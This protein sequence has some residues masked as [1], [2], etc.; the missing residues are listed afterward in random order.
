MACWPSSRESRSGGL[1]SARLKLNTTCA[2]LSLST[3]HV[4]RLDALS[5][6]P[7]G[8]LHITREASRAERGGDQ[9]PLSVPGPGRGEA[10]TAGEAPRVSSRC[11]EGIGGLYIVV[12]HGK[13]S[14]MGIQ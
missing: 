5:P 2:A 7:A 14:G 1:G 4:Y 3:S 8:G 9:C 13:R 11:Q 12:G 10:Q 6:L